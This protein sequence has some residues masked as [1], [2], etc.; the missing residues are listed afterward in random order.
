MEK[1]IRIATILALAF[2]LCACNNNSVDEK[3]NETLQRSVRSATQTDFQPAQGVNEDLEKKDA[4]FLD[5]NTLFIA[6][7]PS[8]WY[9]E[10]WENNSYFPTLQFTCIDS[11]PLGVLDTNFF[12]LQ[13]GKYSDKKYSEEF[14]KAAFRYRDGQEGYRLARSFEDDYDGENAEYYQESLI[15]PDGRFATELDGVWDVYITTERYAQNKKTIEEFYRSIEYQVGGERIGKAQE[16]ASGKQ[17]KINLHVC[18]PS[19]LDMEV[20]VP[21]GILYKREFFENDNGNRELRIRFY[22]DD[23]KSSYVEIFSDQSGFFREYFVT[24]FHFWLDFQNYREKVAYAE[25]KENDIW[26]L[27]YVFWD[28]KAGASVHI[29]EGQEDLCALAKEIVGSVHIK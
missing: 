28:G 12:T 21:E 11:A 15:M 25:Y 6:K 22:L 13:V 4:Y 27:L 2:S 14:V 9:G 19:Y 1:K 24:D 20:E 10:I 29:K 7:I 16:E 3:E 26:R 23:R 18:N 17:N 5:D 8:N